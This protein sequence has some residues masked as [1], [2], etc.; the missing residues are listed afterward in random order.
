MARRLLGSERIG[1][2]KEAN[3]GY[4]TAKPEECTLEDMA[5]RIAC[6]GFKLRII[7][8]RGVMRLR[9]RLRGTGSVTLPLDQS[10]S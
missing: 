4:V 9:L 2:S 6:A 7:K 10:C 8:K 5:R 1:A 3:V